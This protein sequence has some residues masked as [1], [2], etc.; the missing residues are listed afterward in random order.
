MGSRFD[1]TIV[2]ESDEKAETYIDTAVAEIERIENTISEWR[3]QTEISK[4][5]ENAGIKP[6]KVSKELL[7][8]TERALYFSKISDGAF[9]ISFASA[10]KIWKFD[11]SM[12]ELPSADKV[13]ASVKRIGYKNIRINRKNSTLYLRKKG[14]K[15]G[16]GSTGKGYAA[17]KTKELLVAKGIPAGIINASGD[18]NSWG[19]QPD[20]TPWTAAISNPLDKSKVFAILSLDRHTAV[21]TSGNY[22]K[23]AM[24]G[25]KRYSHIINPK[26]GYP[27]SGLASVTILADSAEKANGFSTAIMVLGKEKGLEL[28]SKFPEMQGILV[29]EEGDV[30]TT[31]N[32]RL[33]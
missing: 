10:D 32:I 28:L 1:I 23:F 9:D 26:T 4:V 20:G 15:I 2:H 17:D 11:G 24:I 30:V 12:T 16:F 22:E 13:A 19:A 18:L 29:T 6:V 14:M 5:N 33:K 8:L 7:D 31:P 3:T 25:G 21:V 27:A